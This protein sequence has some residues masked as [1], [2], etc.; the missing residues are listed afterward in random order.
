LS[1]TTKNEY[2]VLDPLE[3]MHVVGHVRLPE[4]LFLDLQKAL[5]VIQRDPLFA[6]P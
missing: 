6:R 1:K 4:Q 2:S 3:D 5:Q